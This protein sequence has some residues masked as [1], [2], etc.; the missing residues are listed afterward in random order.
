M[1]L[2]GDGID[3]AA[4][5]LRIALDIDWRHAPLT[6]CIV[7]NRPLE[8]AP[9]NLAT[10]A[11]ERSQAAGGQLRLCPECDRLYWPGSH[12]RRIQRRLAASQKGTA[13]P[14]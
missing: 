3:E 9:P 14:G 8:A 13:P 1:L 5:A 12:V 6:R 10:R 2:P 7:D 4:R 11:P